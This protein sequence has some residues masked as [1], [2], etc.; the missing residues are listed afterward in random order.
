VQLLGP[1][2]SR[3]DYLA[4]EDASHQV[5]SELFYPLE[6]VRCYGVNATVNGGCITGFVKN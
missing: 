4:S 3:P 5:G 2:S 6:R 1:W